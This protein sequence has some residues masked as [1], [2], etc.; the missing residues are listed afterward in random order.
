MAKSMV[1]KY[2]QILS[3][4]PGSMV[5][6][7]LAKALLDRGEP[8]RA[9]E[10]CQAGLS[11]HPESV[12]GRVLW[13]KA[14]IGT[15]KPAEAMQQFDQAIA[16]DRENPY[17]YNLIGEVLLH[18]GLHR[19]AL[20]ILKKAVALQPNDTRVRQWLEQTTR[21]LNGEKAPSQ[22][23]YTAVDLAAQPDATVP[24]RLSLPAMGEPT[25]TDA[26]AYTPQP[27]APAPTSDPELL[28]G[29]TDV[30]QSLAAR[31]AA[32]AAPSTPPSDVPPPA[33]AAPAEAPE[34]RPAEPSAPGV[35]NGAHAPPEPL[36]Q[37]FASAPARPMEPTRAADEAPPP[38]LIA[39]PAPANVL[40]RDPALTLPPPDLGL[41]EGEQVRMRRP[42]PTEAPLPEELVKATLSR[43]EPRVDATFPGPPPPAP[44]GQSLPDVSSLLASA[45]APEDTV[46]LP[47]AAPAGPPP[48][49]LHSR[50][51]MAA[52]PPPMP[53]K[54][55]SSLLPDLP[56]ASPATPSMELPKVELSSQAAEAIAKEYE[57]E[58]REKLAAAA[59]A[60]KGFWALHGL[61]VGAAALLVL[62]AVVGVG[63]F[64]YA[65]RVHANLPELM[66]QAHAGIEKDTRSSY[67]AAL[68][69]L[70]DLLEV[71]PQN[72]EAHALSGY[73]PDPE[74]DRAADDELTRRLGSAA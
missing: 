59:N 55:S 5:F 8:S 19:S 48:L 17:A 36:A 45:R 16:V 38:S 14:L 71:S 68:S 60:P 52:A 29:M 33:A 58:L 37:A 31:E 2:E 12:V 43:V 50:P 22:V 54:P 62:L 3:A 4:D 69:A 30:F 47:P 41:G 40:A 57:R 66:S 67:Q 7:E 56:S 25:V 21:A 51:K 20:P 18:K 9:I 34:A 6:V 70:S 61:K 73:A 46:E 10:I 53:A 49:N 28:R 24:G 27:A 35:A 65:K 23:Q 39:P 26:K 64:R 44:A 13:G 63:V 15:G 42:E 1:E 72:A 11:H 32:V 74:Q